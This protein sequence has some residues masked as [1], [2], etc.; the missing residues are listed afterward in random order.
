MLL[1]ARWN[2]TSPA[3]AIVK[4]KALVSS[5]WNHPSIKLSNAHSVCTDSGCLSSQALASSGSSRAQ[6]KRSVP[7]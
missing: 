7:A 6:F 1:V 2:F 3:C 5:R 4:A